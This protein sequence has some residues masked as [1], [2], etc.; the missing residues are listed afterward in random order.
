MLLPI[1]TFSFK[2]KR[3]NKA[4]F[5][6]LEH[7]LRLKT[8]FY[9]YDTDLLQR[10][11]EAVNDAAK[12]RNYE[13][14]Y[15][16]KANSNEKLL[17]MIR[18][19]GLGADCVSGN[20]IKKAIEMGFEKQKIVFAGVGKSDEEILIALE[21]DIFCFNC[22]SIEELEVINDLAYSR[23]QKARIALRINP[24]VAANTHKY[25]TT[26]LSQN[27]FGID[28]N[29]I[30]AVCQIL[31][32][33]KNLEFIGLHFHIGSQIRDMQVFEKLAL[34]VNEIILT[35]EKKGFYLQ[36]LNLGGGLGINYEQPEE[37]NIP[38]FERYFA[39]FEKNLSVNPAIKIHFELGRSIVGQC[40]SLISRVLFVKKKLSGL[41]FAIIDAGM[42]ELIR[43]ALYQ[44]YHKIQNLSSESDE[45]MLYDV[46]GPICESSD[47]FGKGIKLPK[48]ERGDLIVLR[49]AGAYGE[50]MS[51]AYN[52]RSANA[53]FFCENSLVC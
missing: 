7:F 49:S 46:V 21:N 18:L 29:E 42:T 10:T 12:K 48:T 45:N 24:N 50:V 30:E 23:N 11:L 33:C 22:E 2:T 16:L 6:P 47:C 4:N 13:I 44:A 19:Q 28:L 26:G 32:R 40:G 53:A 25:I 43:P 14:H 1:S 27:K 41:Q 20:E 51:S 52:L 39:I 31:N 36:H 9:F 15:A 3:M 8:P 35:F 17:A 5:F 34:K 38:N 37:E